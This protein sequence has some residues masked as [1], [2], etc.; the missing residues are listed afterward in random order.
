MKKNRIEVEKNYWNVA[1]QDVEVDRKYI[2]NL[3]EKPV[4][5]KLGKLKHRVLE[6]GCGVGRLMK[7]DYYGIDIS[8]RMIFIAKQR[9]PGCNLQV[10]DGR[11]IPFE[12][13]YFNSVYSVLVFQ[14]IPFQ[15]FL[16]YTMETARVL[17]NG[18]KF[19]FQFIEGDEEEPFSCHY[20]IQ[21]VRHVLKEAG[22]TV[23]SVKKGLGHEQ[24]TW[25]TS[26]KGDSK[27]SKEPD[28]KK[29]VSKN[30]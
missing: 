5:K 8:E 24:W 27:A 21:K 11:T 10:S 12:D 14:H 2:S 16:N 4:L 29:K 18:G 19:I 1:A 7:Q 22:F 25:I 30:G 3:S 20:D 17:R 13:K 23:N 15:G 6:I 9:K 28:L 26:T